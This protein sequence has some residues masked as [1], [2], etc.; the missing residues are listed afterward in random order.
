MSKRDRKRRSGPA[1]PKR[2]APKAGP[3]DFYVR[4][5][6]S[7]R[8][9]REERFR[10]IG[11]H[12]LTLAHARRKISDEQFAAGEEFR[13]LCELRLGCSR[14]STDM[15]PGAG[16]AGS[17]LCFTQAQIDAARRL[18]RLH[19]RIKTRDWII[20]EKFCG[21]GWSM[22]EAVRAATLCHPSGVLFRVQEALDELVVA[23]GG[24]LARSA[25]AAQ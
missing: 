17:R 13:S 4:E 6:V 19:A 7:A 14:D 8:T 10:N 16:G 12:P 1:A 5:F 15:V 3:G 23:R 9:G 20:L 18:E 22:A 24:R 21:E 25:R 11:E 2:T